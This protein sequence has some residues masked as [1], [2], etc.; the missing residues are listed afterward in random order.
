ML[1]L[2]AD[3]SIRQGK[4]LFDATSQRPIMFLMFGCGVVFSGFL[5]T[6][7]LM[8]QTLPEFIR[9]RCVIAA[10]AA[11]KTPVAPNGVEHVR[12]QFDSQAS[13]EHCIPP[14]SPCNI[15]KASEL[16]RNKSRALKGRS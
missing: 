2:D 1:N 13:S 11:S 10:K 16:R 6:S 15:A 7:N 8:M 4:A 3:S 12:R 9:S 14:D 5:A